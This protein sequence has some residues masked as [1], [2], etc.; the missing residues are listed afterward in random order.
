[1]TKQTLCGFAAAFIMLVVVYIFMVYVTLDW[2]FTRWHEGA[3]LFS[4]F[5]A[6]LFGF[7]LYILYKE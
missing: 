7:S 1:M 5:V 6:S 3:R 4:G 2:N